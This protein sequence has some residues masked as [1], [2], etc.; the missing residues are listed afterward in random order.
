MKQRGEIVRNVILLAVGI[1][2]L[3]I[4]STIEDKYGN[5]YSCTYRVNADVIKLIERKPD[6]ITGRSKS[7]PVFR[8][9]YNGELYTYESP[10][11]TDPP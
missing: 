5:R 4:G 11:A 10:L 1:V 3:L 9:E 2:L 7:A 6:S 8:Y